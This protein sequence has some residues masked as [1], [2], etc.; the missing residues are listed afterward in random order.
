[1]KNAA[2]TNRDRAIHADRAGPLANHSTERVHFGRCAL[3]S[4]YRSRVV[5]NRLSIFQCRAALTQLSIS[6]RMF[7]RKAKFAELELLVSNFD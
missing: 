7:S 5:P 1:M 6:E 4:I 2:S 3:L